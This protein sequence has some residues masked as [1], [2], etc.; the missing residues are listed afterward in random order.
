MKLGEEAQVEPKRSDIEAQG[1][2]M[3]DWRY[4]W[5]R[6]TGD[7]LVMEIQEPGQA[8]MGALKVISE[9]WMNGKNVREKGFS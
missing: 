2:G 6:G 3:E 9:D 5:S 7:G 8:R 1:E 4:T